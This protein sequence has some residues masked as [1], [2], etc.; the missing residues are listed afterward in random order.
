MGGACSFLLIV[1]PKARFTFLFQIVKNA[2]KV[3][4]SKSKW[5]STIRV[6]VYCVHNSVNYT[7]HSC[8]VIDKK[9]FLPG[10]GRYCYCVCVLACVPIVMKWA[11]M[12]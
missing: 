3:L 8:F 11:I 1:R 10:F 2:C 5:S 7:L 12:C 4:S 6:M 9:I